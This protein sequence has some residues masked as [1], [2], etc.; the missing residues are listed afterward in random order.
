VASIKIANSEMDILAKTASNI[1]ACCCS[2]NLEGIA[3]A[4]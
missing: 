2:M 3:D 4:D 1:E